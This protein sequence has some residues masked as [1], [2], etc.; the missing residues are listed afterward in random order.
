MMRVVVPREQRVA[1]R[2]RILDRAEAVRKLRPVF[3]RP[4]LGFGKRIVVA[5]ARPRVAGGNR[6]IGEQLGDELAAHRRAAVGVDRQLIRARCP[7][8]AQ[9]AAIS[10]SASC[11]LSCAATIQPTTYRLKRSRITYSEK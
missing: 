2:A 11:A 7:A 3:E 6:Q 9:V 10:R 8:C 4:E 5:H 1:D